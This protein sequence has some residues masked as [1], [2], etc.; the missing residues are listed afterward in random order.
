MST[1]KLRSKRLHYTIVQDNLIR[2]L[3]RLGLTP[4]DFTLW[5]YLESRVNKDTEVSFPGYPKI[6]ADTGLSRQSIARGIRSLMRVRLLTRERQTGKPNL[7]TTF[8]PPKSLK[9]DGWRPGEVVPLRNEGRSA[10]ERGVVPLRN[11][12][13]IKLK[14]VKN[15]NNTPGK[16]RPASLPRSHKNGRA[17]LIAPQASLPLE[18][19]EAVAAQIEKMALDKRIRALSVVTKLDPRTSYHELERGAKFLMEKNASPAQLRGFAAWYKADWRSNGGKVPTVGSLMKYWGVYLA[20]AAA[21]ERRGGGLPM[22][23]G[24]GDLYGGR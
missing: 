22:L 16:K 14:E 9:A 13:Y 6:M 10:T 7:Y 8:D 2:N 19:V 15:K 1:P 18:P 21:A 17:K 24:M 20:E 5:C 23:Q 3:T 12:K 11:G 4:E